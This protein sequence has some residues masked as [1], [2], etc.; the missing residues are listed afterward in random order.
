MR[1]NIIAQFVQLLKCW[2]CDMW[3]GIVTENW[4]LSADQCQLQALQFSVYLL[5]L[6]SIFLR[7]NGF[8]GIQKVF[9]DQTGSRPPNSDHDLFLVQVWLD[10]WKKSYEQPR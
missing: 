4:A 1:Q 7:C 3:S 6:L 9:V 2:L 10:P 5:D 8:T